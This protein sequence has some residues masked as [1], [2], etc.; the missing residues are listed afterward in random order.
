MLLT[1]MRAGLRRGHGITGAAKEGMIK[2]HG[3]NTELRRVEFSKDVMSIVGAVIVANTR[4][5]A[6]H[7]EMRTPVVLA[8]QGMEDRFTRACI[9]HGGRMHAEN[10][11]LIGVVVIQQHFLEFLSHICWTLLVFGIPI[12]GVHAG[13][14]DRSPYSVLI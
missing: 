13:A 7:D 4:V 12:P 2:E 1:A 8:H 14:I 5:V 11:A 6:P 3:C 9:E 10:E